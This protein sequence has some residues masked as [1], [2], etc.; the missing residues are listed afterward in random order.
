[1]LGMLGMLNAILEFCESQRDWAVETID[2]LARLESPTL[3]K[4][5]VD[6]CGQELRRRLAAMG[7]RGEQLPREQTGDHLLVEFG[8]G[9]RQQVL[10]LGHFDTVWPVGQIGRM[11]IKSENGRLYGPG[12]FDMKGGIAIG[13]LATRALCEV[14][15]PLR[16]RVVM[17]WTADEERGSVSSREV[18]AEQ[19]RLSDAV[20]VLEPSGPGGA[21][22]T[23]RKGCG[24]YEL[25][26][27]GRSAHAGVDPAKGASA[28]HELARQIVALEALQD[29]ERGISVNV[30]VIG[31]GTR[32]N[33]VAEHASAIIDVRAPTLADASRVDE[34]L[35]TL[36]ARADGV[37]IHLRGGFERPPLER[38]SSVARLYELAR[39]VAA[40]LGREL[41][42][43]SSGGGSDGNL[44]AALGVPTLDGLGAVGEGPHALHEHIEIDAIPWRAALVA[45]LLTRLDEAT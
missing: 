20:L 19:A 33:V 42:E 35:R 28:V 8:S 45:G 18:I 38:S 16:R 23:S 22:K 26:V 17:L 37:S 39:A 5:A 44:T 11:P 36:R 24:E 29:L 4:R 43:G 27:K 12:V 32:P 21:L 25:T 7:G 31:G 13:M 15:P 40:D 1:M 2:T 3:D 30:G 10:I 41:G 14:G 34:V 9:T 6:V